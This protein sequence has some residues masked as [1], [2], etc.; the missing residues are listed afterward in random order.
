MYSVHDT[1]ALP[2]AGFPIRKSP[3]QS[4]FSG[5]PKL[6]AAYHV[7]HRLP[8]PRH[9]PYALCSLTIKIPILQSIYPGHT[10]SSVARFP[11]PVKSSFTAHGSRI[12]DHDIRL[13]TNLLCNCQ[14][15]SP[16]PVF[17][18][19][20]SATSSYGTRIT[21]CGPRNFG[22]GERVRTDGLLR[23]RQALSQLSYTPDWVG[24]PGWTRTTDL[25]IISRVL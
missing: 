11:W 10:P 1:E 25:T 5:S 21:K 13:T 3:D 2:P 7:L 14:R 19:P 9:P 16:S 18:C 23:A 15:T 22:G 17:R 8:L 4:L 12:P 24:G 6:I 20:I